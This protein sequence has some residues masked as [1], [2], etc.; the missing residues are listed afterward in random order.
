MAQVSASES[1]RPQIGA[2]VRR[3]PLVHFLAIAAL[4]FAINSIVETDDREVITVDVATQE[5]LIRQQED[6][7]LRNLTGEEQREAVE[8][9]VDDDVLVREARKRG[10]DN[11]SRVRRL[12]IQ[13]M[14]F[15]LASDLAEPDEQ[16]LR[17]Y[18]EANPRSFETPPSVSYDHVFFENPESV[19][20]G[21][22]AGLNS[23]IDYTT[24]GNSNPLLDSRLLKAG[25]RDIAS[26]FGPEEA[27]R[28]LAIDG[29]G[30][31][32]PFISPSG[33]HFLRI[34]ERHEAQPA[35]FEEVQGWIETDWR[36]NT[37]REI[38]KREI[39]EMRKGYRIEI[40]EA[41]EDDE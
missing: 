15:F 16:E 29:L 3:E 28:V 32:G 4:L 37:Q 2:F 5:F 6:L 35:R 40:L 31:H 7:L 13:N 8:A 41:A 10:L 17:N 24:A 1:E 39:A 34:A 38:M 12:L 11:S 36:L 21:L 22:L 18:F 33:A 14:R 19:P 25:L 9:F 30:W 20:D 27:P 23:G 26:A